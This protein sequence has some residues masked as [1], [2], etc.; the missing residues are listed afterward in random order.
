MGGWVEGFGSKRFQ[1]EK[2]GEGVKKVSNNF[3]EGDF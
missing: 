3:V 2:R 1:L